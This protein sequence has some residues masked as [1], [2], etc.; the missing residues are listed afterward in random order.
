M[1]DPS[2]QTI[3]A[4]VVATVA[5]VLDTQAFGDRYAR[6]MQVLI[7]GRSVYTP[8]LGGVDWSALP[9]SVIPSFW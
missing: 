6:R 1:A 4:G 7:D 2:D 3:P 5:E 8:A 9:L